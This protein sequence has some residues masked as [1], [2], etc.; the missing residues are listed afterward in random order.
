VCGEQLTKLGDAQSLLDFGH[1][2][3]DSEAA[4][5]F[6]DQSQVIQ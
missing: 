2:E 5:D 6:G 1:R 3:L 4:L